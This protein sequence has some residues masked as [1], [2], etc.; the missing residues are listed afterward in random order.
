M[1][2]ATLNQLQEQDQYCSDNLWLNV[3]NYRT[4]KNN[5]NGIMH[6]AHSRPTG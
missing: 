1:E 2:K 3:V 5:W 6:A 4:K